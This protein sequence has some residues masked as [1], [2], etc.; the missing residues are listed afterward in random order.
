MF[1]RKPKPPL[2][3]AIHCIN[4]A[5]EAAYQH[6]RDRTHMPS[7]EELRQLDRLVEAL[8]QN[9]ATVRYIARNLHQRAC[10]EPEGARKFTRGFDYY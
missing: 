2:E 7:E 4:E 6:L 9:H 3:E 1:K 8:W 10:G 5:V